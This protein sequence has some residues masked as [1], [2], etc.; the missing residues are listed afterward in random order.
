MFRLPHR[1]T[2]LSTGSGSKAWESERKDGRDDIWLCKPQEL[3]ADTSQTSHKPR[4]LLMRDCAAEPAVVT[5]ALHYGCRNV[6]GGPAPFRFAEHLAGQQEKI[7]VTQVAVAERMS[8]TEPVF[9]GCL[10]CSVDLSSRGRVV[11]MPEGH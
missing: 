3:V 8:S 10:Q 2:S 11:E 7:N 1:S 9:A 6:V 4:R 5:Y